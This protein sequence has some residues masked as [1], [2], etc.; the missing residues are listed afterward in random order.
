MPDDVSTGPVVVDVNDLH[1][2]YPGAETDVLRGLAFQIRDG[3]V[4]GFLGPSGSG[5]STTQK[6][7]TGRLDGFRGTARI[8]GDAPGAQGSDYFE[9][10]GVGFER[11]HVYSRLTGRENL[12]F[13]RDLYDGATADPDALLDQVG[14]GDAADVRADSYSKGMRG[15]LDFCRALLNDPELLFLDE[16]TSGLDPTTARLVKDLIR[17]RAEQG[18]T[19]F[20]TTHDMSAAS[21]LC[22]RV[23][24]LVDGRIEA[25][26]APR[27]FMVRHGQRRVGVEYRTN[28]H[29]ERSE[30][31]LDDLGTDGAF[32][33][34]LRTQPIERIHTMDA[35]LEDVF[36][37]V[38][39]RTL[40]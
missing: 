30:F 18:T 21:E 26:D 27:D 36:I 20:L 4:F 22:D 40:T 10:V 11:P 28:H 9:R 35:T 7:L 12:A 14:L 8:F 37:D 13:F 16:P 25:V 39:G 15:R 32:V 17:D 6:I 31:D 38:T 2:A 29:L 3:E 34:L 19:V 23:A 33:E 1:F 24:F 5:K